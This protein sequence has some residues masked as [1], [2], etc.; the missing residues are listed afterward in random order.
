LL[1]L[2]FS[3]TSVYL[4]VIVPWFS[5]AALYFGSPLPNTF[6]A[7]A[8]FF[9]G[10]SF[11]MQGWEL[12]KVYYGNN[13]LHLAAP[14]L[15]LFGVVRLLRSPALRPVAVWCLAY[16]TGYTILNTTYFW[17]YVPL[18]LGLLI[19][20]AFGAD[21]AARY[22]SWRWNTNAGFGL[23]AIYAVVTLIAGTVTV[24]PLHTLP[25]RMAT[26]RLAG[27]WIAEN[28]LA[29]A[30]LTVADLGITG[31][32]ARR[33]TVDTFG[34][35]TKNNYSIA[36][37][38]V[39]AKYR[40]DYV[41]LTSYYVFDRLRTRQWFNEQYMPVM[42]FSTPEDDEFS[43]MTLYARKYPLEAPKSIVQGTP[44]ALTCHLPLEAGEAVPRTVARVFNESGEQVARA[45]QR[46]RSGD[47]RIA[48]GQEMLIDQI[49]V[50]TDALSPGT[51]RWELQCT[52]VSSGTF[53]VV[54]LDEA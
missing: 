22:M 48:I 16:G 10:W 9:G 25:S 40:T 50:Q 33:H 36:P 5:F 17:Y 51:Y 29:T 1:R 54:P 53:T 6:S 49:L 24:Y 52:E 20:L 2:L 19:C 23:I 12:V 34:L 7:K 3:S 4:I 47:Y 26:Y 45:N 41:L 11:M 30:T 27:E 18:T 21:A 44:L 13:P 35:I 14:I 32:Y 43:P 28:T 31:Y 38:Y 39:L 46:F 42:S 15:I 8:D 37:D